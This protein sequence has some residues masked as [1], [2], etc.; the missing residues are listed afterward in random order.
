M[1]QREIPIDKLAINRYKSL[2]KQTMNIKDISNFIPCGYGKAR[3]ISEEIKKSI[4]LEGLENLFGNVVRTRRVMKYLGISEND[5][6]NAYDRVKKSAKSNR[7][8]D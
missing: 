4:K 8:E 7:K 3:E 6:L 1:R 2:M 5:I